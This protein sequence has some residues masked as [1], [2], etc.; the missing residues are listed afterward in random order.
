MRAT[1]LVLTLLSFAAG[2]EPVVVRGLF[3]LQQEYVVTHLCENRD[4]PEKKC[5]GKCFLKKRMEDAHQHDGAGQQL[6]PNV[7]VG[8]N[9]LAP[10]APALP[11]RPAAR[12]SYPPEAHL[13][14]AA[15]LLPD[16]IHPPERAA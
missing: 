2:L 15:G 5:N 7:L 3:A 12:R 14:L 11:A 6:L 9:L 10:S 16:V 1:V 4:H 8:F 13:H